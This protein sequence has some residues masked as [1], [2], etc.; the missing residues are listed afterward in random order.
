[1][2]APVRRLELG[3]SYVVVRN[4]TTKAAWQ[5]NTRDSGGAQ[6]DTPGPL[7]VVYWF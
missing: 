3:G 1:M 7:Q 4:I 6:R 2:G 5:C